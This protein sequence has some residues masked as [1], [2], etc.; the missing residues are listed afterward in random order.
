M[1]VAQW[2]HNLGLAAY[3]ALFREQA[4]D[5]DVLP[6]LTDADLEKLG[7]PLGHRKKL[8][9]AIAALAA[10]P[11][12]KAPLLPPTQ[13]ERRQLTVMF[14]DLVGSTALAVRMDPEDLREVIAAFRKCVAEVI[15]RQEGFVAKYM[16][17]G[18][19][20]YFGYPQAHEYDAE[21]AV[22]A[23]MALVE[24]VGRLS[25]AGERL[26]IR[27]GI[28]T[29]LVVVGDLIGLGAAQEEVVVGETPN[30]A[31]RLQ[32]LAQ[33]NAV[34]IADRTHR[35]TGGLFDYENLGRL[36][37]KGF[38]EPVQA[39]R[40]VGE[41]AVLSRFEA[42]H[43][44]ELTPFVGRGE[45]LRLLLHRWE[46]AKGKEGQVVLLSG[47]PGI[48]KSRITEELLDRLDHEPHVRFRY[49]CSPYHV[50][51]ALYPFKAQLERLAGFRSGDRGPVKLGKLE[52]LLAP[53]SKDLATDV[54]LIAE[55]LSVSSGDRYPSLQIA[56]QQKKEMTLAALLLHLETVT[57]EQPVL[58]VFEDAHWID[59]TSLELLDRAIARIGD[60]PV[61]LLVTFRPEFQPPWVGR[62]HVLMRP[63]GRLGRREGAA[64]IAG[65]TVGKSLPKELTD[66]VLERA[67][68]VAL[69]I[70]E[71]TSTVLESGLLREEGGAYVLDGPLTPLALPTTL[72]ASL[73]ARLDRLGSAKNVAQIGS[74]IGREFSHELLAAVAWHSERELRDALGKL[75]DSGLIFR[76]GTPPEASYA[77]KH[78]LVQD[79]AYVTLLRSRRKQ[80]HASIGR[81]L[82]ARFPAYVQAHPE[83][84]AR[85]Y[86]DARFV[87]Q[88][89]G[90]WLKAG[91]LANDRSASREAVSHLTKGL[92][93]LHELPNDPDRDRIELALQS[94][95]GPALVATK[96]YAAPEAVAAYERARELMRATNQFSLQGGV[97]AGLYA[98]YF[99]LAKY[100][101]CFGIGRELLET[102]ERRREAVGLC[103][104]N[105]MIAACN[106]L[107]GNFPTAHDYAERAWSYYDPERDGPLAWRYAHDIGV[108]AKSHLAIAVWHLGQLE[109]SASLASEVFAMAQRSAHPNTIGHSLWYAGSVLSFFARDF[110]AL[111]V[112]S[113]RLQAFGREHHLPNWAV[114]GALLEPPALAATGELK[115]AI[116]QVDT[117]IALQEQTKNTSMKPLVLVGIAEVYLRAGRG[118]R[119]V[120]VIGDALVTA[121][122][123]GELWMNAELWRLRAAA[124]LAADGRKNLEEA[125]ACYQRAMTIAE[126]QGSRM[127]R[128]RAATSLAKLMVDQGQREEARDLLEPIYSW[129]T[130]GF[131]TPDLKDAKALLCELGQ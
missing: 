41:S 24:A 30:L 28:A 46:Q 73:V 58:M 107:R 130:E 66:Q 109:R 114:R 96:G 67:D 1:D 105:R 20:V 29:G 131:S 111:R 6:S 92:E 52:G 71:L 7:L 33:P 91:Q 80:L 103:L 53:T 85:H 122:A 8:L 39:W 11:L 65:L 15:G 59:P 48:G 22:R 129:F 70:E 55:L 106:N 76:R 60:L 100:D 117:G 16:G 112:F 54:A 40:V 119:A 17:D 108:A 116:A 2:L 21:R 120:P 14:V 43:S 68:G 97:L 123:S 57:A 10:A 32:A 94:T 44:G 99:G 63:L 78:T 79:A 3:A 88:A 5:A 118:D 84:V 12:S 25:V 9:D 42:M 27:A 75:T 82:E 34:V 128:L 93:L 89:M 98:C 47:E 87:T 95:I 56:P 90:Y 37:A 121:E 81:E 74:A 126:G 113:D 26:Q 18:V 4:I 19:L 49:F 23:G 50:D 102:A 36:A 83:V 124:H 77:F 125:Q 104:A 61:L 110:S 38:A 31:A 72:Q 101:K 62:A 115:K 45:E 35:L 51:S 13:A 86:T 64:L 127:F 69:F